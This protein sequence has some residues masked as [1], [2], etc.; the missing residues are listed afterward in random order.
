MNLKNIGIGILIL[1]GLF[2]VSL[3]MGTFVSVSTEDVVGE[4]IGVIRLDGIITY[5]EAAGLLGGTY[6][7]EDVIAQL[8]KARTAG[9]IREC[10]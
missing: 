9:H 7:I 6:D 10:C 5:Q 1:I 4:A 8:E 3:V 2:L